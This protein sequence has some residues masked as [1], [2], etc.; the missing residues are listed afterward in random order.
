[1]D[2]V[3]VKEITRSFG[4]VKAVDGVSFSVR[5][6]ELFGL[7]GP[8]GAGKTTLFRLLVTL[9][10]PD[11][12]EAYVDGLHVVRD[13]RRLRPRLGYM[14]GRF[15]L[16]P[17]LS[18]A[19]NLRFFASVFGTTVEA[20]Y[21]LVKGIYAA[22]EPF[23]DRP[24]GKLSGGMKQ[25][26]A[27]SCALIH[28][29]RVLFLDEPTTG[30]DAVSRQEFWEMLGR[31]KASGLTIVVSTPYMDEARRCDRVALM[32][33]GRLLTVETPARIEAMYDR[34][35]FAVRGKNR[36]CLLQ[37]L[38]AYPHV[39]TAYAFGDALHYTDA[40]P[41]ADPEAL[42]RDLAAAGFPDAEVTP[43]RATIEDVFMALMQTEEAHGDH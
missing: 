30:V 38:R 9:L 2:A 33:A 35:L 39:H 8:D 12:G 21:D 40:R 1:M 25:K 10:L 17:D 41:T 20:N 11:A 22:L 14:P 43:I 34:P 7:I 23:R 3:V 24:A 32:Q 28:R 5:E 13:Y 31:L 42:R 26:L 36:Y 4:A 18:V 15:S 19:E 6:G 29:P 16:Y 37:A 27:L